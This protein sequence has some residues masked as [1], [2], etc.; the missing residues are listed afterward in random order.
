MAIQIWKA[1][2]TPLHKAIR[3]IQ[4]KLSVLR[5]TEKLKTT[6]ASKTFKHF[7]P[8]SIDA[9][10]CLAGSGNRTTIGSMGARADRDESSQAWFE[11]TYLP[12]ESIQNP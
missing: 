6:D 3:K 7:S 10:A 1:P 11:H 2:Y 5:V 8:V 12:L 4:T 9:F